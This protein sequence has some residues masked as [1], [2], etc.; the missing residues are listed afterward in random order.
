MENEFDWIEDCYQCYNKDNWIS[1]REYRKAVVVQG[2]HDHCLIDAKRLSSHDYDDSEKQG[3]CSTDGNIWLCENCFNEIQKRH[4][5]SVIENTVESIENDLSE[6]KTVVFSLENQQ[7][8][9]KNH[10]GKIIV[11]HKDCIKKYDNL[12]SMMREQL[13]YGEYLRNIIDKIF[14]GVV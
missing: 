6:F 13:F 5:L 8:I 9:I 3:Y 2:D 10:S 4:N 14:V 12:L 11:E 1:K 7:Y